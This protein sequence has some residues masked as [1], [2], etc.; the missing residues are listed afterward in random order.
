[1]DLFVIWLET[2]KKKKKKKGER[3][4]KCNVCQDIYIHSKKLKNKGTKNVEQNQWIINYLTH[5]TLI[6]HS[7][8][9]SNVIY[10]KQYYNTI[11]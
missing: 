2:Q 5:E 7:L 6:L 4:I 8:L 3:A 9:F 11:Y 10:I 1:M